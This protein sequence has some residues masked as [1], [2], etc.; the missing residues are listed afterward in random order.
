MGGQNR[1][2]S[3][4]SSSG[5]NVLNQQLLQVL[6]STNPQ[7]LIQALQAQQRGSGKYN[8]KFYRTFKLI[9]SGKN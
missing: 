5:N 1:G 7:A 3:N 4:G 8:I 9:I 6:Q 2:A